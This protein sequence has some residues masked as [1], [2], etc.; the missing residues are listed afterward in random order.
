MELFNNVTAHRFFLLGISSYILLKS[1]FPYFLKN[2]E[3]FF[4][5]YSH[6]VAA[7]LFGKKVEKFVVSQYGECGVYMDGANNIIRRKSGD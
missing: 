6:S 7:M 5:E 1:I 4:H 3:L 2:Q